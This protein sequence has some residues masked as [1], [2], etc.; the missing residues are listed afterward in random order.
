MLR[1]ALG[2][3][4]RRRP[5]DIMREMVVHLL[6]EGGI[7][8]GLAHRPFPVRGSAASASRRRSGRHRCRN[9]RARRDRCGRNWACWMVMRS[10]PCVACNLGRLT[11]GIRFAHRPHKGPNSRRVLDARHASRPRTRHRPRGARVIASACPTLPGSSPP[12]SMKGTPG[13]RPIRSVQSKGRP[14]P[15]GRVASLRRAGVEQQPVRDPGI[16]SG[17]GKIG[18]GL[19]R[20]RLHHRQAEAGAQRR[21]RVPEAPCRGVAA[22]RD[23]APRRSQRMCASSASTV[24]ATFFARP[25]ARAPSMRASSIADMA[26]RRRKEHEADEVGARLERCIE[27][28]GRAKP[29]DFDKSGHAAGVLAR[30]APLVCP[31]AESVFQT[32]MAAA[33]SSIAVPTDLNKR[34]LRIRSAALHLAARQRSN[35]SPL[36][37]LASMIFF[38]IG[39]TMSPAS[40]AAPARVSTKMRE[41]FTA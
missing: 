24:S 11:R 40:F 15:P 41:R 30:R 22:C 27:R 1:H 13:S 23:R 12:E 33:R 31:Q 32:S 35:R 6:L 25:A 39:M 38:F 19:D 18:R 26:R 3:I 21:Q 16:G 17:G 20:Q 34:D 2:E 36:I 7:G 9:A 29:A 37:A 28:I 4:E 5:P 14:S 10:G 8:L